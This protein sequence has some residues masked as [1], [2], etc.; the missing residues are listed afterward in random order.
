MR[1]KDKQLRSSCTTCECPEY[2]FNAS[3]SKCD[4][5]GCA[6]TRHRI[7]QELRVP[8]E[9]YSDA[10][11]SDK[12]P[13]PTPTAA[14]TQS[15]QQ[16]PKQQFRLLPGRSQPSTTP[17]AK[18]ETVSYDEMIS[19]VFAVA[20]LDIKE[21]L[22]F[23]LIESLTLDVCQRQLHLWFPCMIILS[24]MALLGRDYSEHPPVLSRL[25]MNSTFVFVM[26]SFVAY[27]TYNNS[28]IQTKRVLAGALIM[29]NGIMAATYLLL[30]LRLLPS[31][32]GKQVDQTLEPGR[33]L[34]WLASVP[35]LIHVIGDTTTNAD[36]LDMYSKLS[37]VQLLSMFACSFYPPKD[38]SLPTLAWI[39]S[40]FLIGRKVH[41]LYN[42]AVA[43][44]DTAMMD[45]RSLTLCKVFAGVGLGL[46]SLTWFLKRGAVLDH[47]VAESLYSLG[48]TASVAG[49]TAILAFSDIRELEEL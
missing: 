35:A 20:L 1:D 27:M 15:R 22:G 2:T 40:T 36:N 45:R 19:W 3:S 8:G 29:V 30:L 31:L 34:T 37:Y 33:Y 32:P 39:A 13:T 4:E 41:G 21:L 48:D 11:A 16:Q 44:P 18:H 17:P 23:R 14:S 25:Y 9:F 46:V 12:V 10:S 26:S 24:F 42:D 5:C 38:S 6:V 43:N 7:V 28:K 47:V 49:L